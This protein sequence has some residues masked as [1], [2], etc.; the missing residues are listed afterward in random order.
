MT[1]LGSAGSVSHV[2]SRLTLIVRPLS[3]VSEVDLN[4]VTFVMVGVTLMA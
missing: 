3:S 4:S 1:Q 2:Q